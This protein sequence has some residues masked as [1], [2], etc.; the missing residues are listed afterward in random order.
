MNNRE[1]N[2]TKEITGDIALILGLI[3]ISLIIIPYF[4]FQEFLGETKN[5]I[6]SLLLGIIGLVL[7]K[8]QSKIFVDDVSKTALGLNLAGII[9]ATIN[10]VVIFIK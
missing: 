7:S 5:T 8:V 3:S 4:G 2:I 1:M 10:G 6:L 9:I